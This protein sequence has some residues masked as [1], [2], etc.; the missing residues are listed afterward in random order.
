MSENIELYSSHV[1]T[2]EELK[3]VLLEADGILTGDGHIGRLSRDGTKHVFIWLDDMDSLYGSYEPSIQELL[4]AKLGA[5]AT[6]SLVIEIGMT[7]GSGLLCYC[8]SCLASQ[9]VLCF[10][11]HKQA[12]ISIDRSFGLVVWCQTE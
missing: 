8:L 7:P 4:Q 12:S 6:Y 3:S 11:L 2:L 1:I 10:C 5:E 9:V